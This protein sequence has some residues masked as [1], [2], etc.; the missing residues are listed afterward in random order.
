MV[1]A[2]TTERWP[3]L[4]AAMASI[5]AQ[6]PTPRQTILVTD[7]NAD[8][9][10]RA[11]I[12]FP[13]VLVVENA[14]QQG[15]SGARNT[16]LACSDSDVVAFLDDDACALPG[17]LDALTSAYA[18]PAV[19]GVGGAAIP[20]WDEAEPRWFPAEFSWVIGCSWV[21][22]PEAATGVRNL[23][24]CNMSFRR[25]VFAEIG[26]FT[27]GMGR[28]GKVPVGCEETELCIRVHQQR[29]DAVILYDPDVRVLHTM[30]NDRRRWRYFRARCYA[31]GLSKAMVADR[32]GPT[33]GLA[34]ERTY[35]AAHAAG[36]CDAR[37]RRRVAPTLRGRAGPGRRDRGRPRDH[38][39][40]VRTG[41]V[42][43]GPGPSSSWGRQANGARLAS[44]AMTAT[45]TVHQDER[46]STQ[47]FAPVIVRDRELSEPDSRDRRPTHGR[48]AAPNRQCV[49]RLHHEPLGSVAIDLPGGVLD[50]TG[51]ADAIWSELRGP[52][53]AHLTA[54]GL[55]T[56]A[57]LGPEGLSA[58]DPTEGRATW[59]TGMCW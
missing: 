33:D 26:E 35:V 36:R 21:G 32:V 24:G 19:T 48:D 45:R 8:L 11:R 10:K 46:R 4:V 43:I 41:A 15:L 39:H 20:V 53:N 40:R 12:A 56:V 16:G 44:G 42:G 5:A 14:E 34:S 52:I 17:W 49:D 38:R 57:R 27:L 31:E 2:Y 58:P 22:L 30:S 37:L 55:P 29:P 51:V 13:D 47:D 28:V 50:A 25:E 18:D 23:I 1:C 59:V 9:T 7:H 6:E 54:F 3:E